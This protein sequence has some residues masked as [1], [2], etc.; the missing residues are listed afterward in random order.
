M[1]GSGCF[2]CKILCNEDFSWI[3]V[4]TE[5]PNVPLKCSINNIIHIS[6][7]DSTNSEDSLAPLPPALLWGGEGVGSVHYKDC[8]FTIKD[9]MIIDHSASPQLHLTP[10]PNGWVGLLSYHI[11]I[12]PIPGNGENQTSSPIFTELAGEKEGRVE[13][14]GRVAGKRRGSKSEE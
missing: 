4:I 8:D 7:D 3:N 6:I 5:L 11:Q 14:A 13:K 12:P 1:P 9:S 2:R 10:R